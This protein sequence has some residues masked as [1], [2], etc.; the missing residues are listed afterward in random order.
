MTAKEQFS[1]PGMVHVTTVVP[2]EKNEPEA[3]AQVA[4]PQPPAT[5]GGGYETLPPHAVAFVPI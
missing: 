4:G 3:G 1:P 5:S 2:T